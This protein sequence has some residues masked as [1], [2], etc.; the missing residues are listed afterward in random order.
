MNNLREFRAS[1]EGEL[2]VKPVKT[3]AE[4]NAIL[5]S[6][7]SVTGQ[8]LAERKSLLKQSKIYYFAILYIIKL[9]N[10]QL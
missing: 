1:V 10:L 3:I 2:A 4:K 9:H 6:K 8:E 7:L 5:R